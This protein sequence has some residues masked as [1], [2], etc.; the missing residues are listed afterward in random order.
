MNTHAI[1]TVSMWEEHHSN[2]KITSNNMF[3]IGCNNKLNNLCTVSLVDHANGNIWF[4][5][6]I[7]SLG[8]TSL[9]MNNVQLIT[10]INTSKSL[11]QH[12]TLSISVY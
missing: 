7:Q 2:D 6:V 8:N 5:S 1:A 4:Q 3:Q 10:M 12:A 9:K 11:L